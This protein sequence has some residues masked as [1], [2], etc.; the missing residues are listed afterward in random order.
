MK[1]WFL[2]LSLLWATP[3]FAQV[4]MIEARGPIRQLLSEN[5]T[6]ANQ[7]FVGQADIDSAW[8]GALREIQ[9]ICGAI[10]LAN[11]KIKIDSTTNIYTVSGDTTARLQAVY[12]TFSSVSNRVRHFLKIVD[13][14]G[15]IPLL[16]G[17]PGPEYC[18]L[19]NRSL[20]VEPWPSRTES[21]LVYQYRHVKIPTADTMN[22]NLPA[23]LLRAPIWI[24]AGFLKHQLYQAQTAELY[25]NRGISIALE[26][27]KNYQTQSWGG[28]YPVTAGGK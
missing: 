15:T 24:A 21:L 18:F 3:L 4:D 25:Y 14:P 7:V 17:H 1:R 9:A 10:V 11:T 2:I 13:A 28:A 20:V 19:N 8:I 27:K 22:T 5:S 26:W 16:K 23:E 12:L 6:D